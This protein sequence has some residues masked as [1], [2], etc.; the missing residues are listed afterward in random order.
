[1]SKGNDRTRELLEALR[2]LFEY[3][4]PVYRDSLLMNNGELQ[5]FG[6]RVE[7]LLNEKGEY[8]GDHR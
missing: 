5:T 6:E 3:G 8:D 1:M 7:E 2:E 4:Y